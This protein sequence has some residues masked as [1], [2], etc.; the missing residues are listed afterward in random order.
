M[1][2]SEGSSPLPSS[3]FCVLAQFLPVIFTHEWFCNHFLLLFMLWICSDWN[4]WIFDLSVMCFVFENINCS[5]WSRFWSFLCLNFVDEYFNRM[6]A[7]WK[8]V[9]CSS[10]VWN[11]HVVRNLA[12]SVVH[13]A[14]HCTS[15]NYVYTFY[16]IV[17]PYV[18][19][20]SSTFW[21]FVNHNIIL[22]LIKHNIILLNSHNH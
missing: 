17:C 18:I 19:L 16:C 9:R 3:F 8:R 4:D 2:C 13:L 15:S 7:E 11:N 1:R 12:V 22:S 20:D 14:F 5:L 21:S 6:E 10:V